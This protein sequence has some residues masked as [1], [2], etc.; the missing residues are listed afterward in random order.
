MGGDVSLPD[1]GSPELAW[2]VEDAAVHHGG[3]AIDG[4]QSVSVPSL[5]ETSVL[6][7]M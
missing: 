1:F 3:V 6:T 4:P 7:A 2:H 5:L